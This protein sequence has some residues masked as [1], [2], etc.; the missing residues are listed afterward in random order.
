MTWNTI[1]RKHPKHVALIG[2]IAIETGNL[3]IALAT[4]FARMLS[5]PMRTGRAVYLTPKAAHAQLDIL[6][7]AAKAAFDRKVKSK[8]LNDQYKEALAKVTGIISRAGK[9]NDKRNRIVSRFLGIQ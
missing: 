6:R 1:L 4:L 2:M 9:A 7:N 5:V 3:E 8:E